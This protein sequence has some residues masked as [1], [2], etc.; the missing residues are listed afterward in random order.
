MIEVTREFPLPEDVFERQRVL[1]G[2]YVG[3][4]RQSARPIRWR[5][6][7]IAAVIVVVGAAAALAVR[8]YLDK[9]FIGLPPEGAAPSSPETGT[10]VLSYMGR[11]PSLALSGGVPLHSVSVYADGRLI[12]RRE[13]VVWPRLPGEPT[14]YRPFWANAHSSGLLEQRLTREGVELMRSEVISSGLF[15]RNRWLISNGILWGGIRV[16]NGNRLV[17]VEWLPPHAV[18]LDTFPRRFRYR[19]QRQEL[20]LDRLTARLVA[21]GSWLP[22]T[23]WKDRTIRA[24]VPARYGACLGSALDAIE[25]VEIMR[26]LPEAA[27]DRLHTKAVGRHPKGCYAVTT[28]DARAIAEALENAG[29]KRNKD[30]FGLRYSV[31]VRSNGRIR[32]AYVEFDPLLPNGELACSACG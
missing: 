13:G 18:T 1:V 28:E 19:T 14:G 16:R 9:G 5:V 22:P 6:L 29:F 21:P 32:K 11:S 2:A 31:P 4:G 7:A 27:R 3:A 8:A 26:R 23:A 10:L 24:Y 25:P 12:W 17:R 30:N 15:D 20:V